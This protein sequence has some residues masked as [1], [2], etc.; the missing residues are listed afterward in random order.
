MLKDPYS[1]DIFLMAPLHPLTADTHKR[2]FLDWNTECLLAATS[3]P[4]PMIM[5][6]LMIIAC[7]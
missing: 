3:S 6:L 5:A 4:C 1:E 7:A 2:L